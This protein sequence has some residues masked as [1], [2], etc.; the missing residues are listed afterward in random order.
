MS[1]V[2]ALGRF[3]ALI[4]AGVAAEMIVHGIRMYYLEYFA[5]TSSK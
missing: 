2:R 3:M 1:T 5:P 4:I